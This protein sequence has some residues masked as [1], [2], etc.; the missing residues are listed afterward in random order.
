MRWFNPM[1]PFKGVR[2][3]WLIF[4]KNSALAAASAFANTD[5]RKKR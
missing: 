1:M 3:S 5:L 2:I 4:D